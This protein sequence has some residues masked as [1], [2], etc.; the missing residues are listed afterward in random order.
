MRRLE[1]DRHAIEDLGW[2]IQNERKLAVRL[3]RILEETPTNP[4]EG[5]GKPEPLRGDLAGCWSRRLNQEH[6]V[7]YRVGD[8]RIL[9]LACRFHYQR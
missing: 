4:F 6:R 7:V 2:L 5:I 9:V 1:L 8:D 3:L